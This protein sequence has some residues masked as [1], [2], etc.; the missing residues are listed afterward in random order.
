MPGFH[1]CPLPCIDQHAL[2][3]SVHMYTCNS[4]CLSAFDCQFLHPSFL[5]P[6]SS[7]SSLL[8]SSF[9]IYVNQMYCIIARSVLFSAFGVA[10][11]VFEA[12]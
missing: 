7:L 2:L 5:P 1:H 3:E 9:Q 6:L 4:I 10:Y 11:L 8:T 12:S